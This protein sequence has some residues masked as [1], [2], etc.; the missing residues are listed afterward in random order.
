MRGSFFSSAKKHRDFPIPAKEDTRRS[1]N[2]VLHPAYRGGR[3]FPPDSLK[4]IGM[5][6]RQILPCSLTRKEPIRQPQSHP[7]VHFRNGSLESSRIDRNGGFRRKRFPRDGKIAIFPH[8]IPRFPGREENL[9]S[10]EKI[11]RN[12]REWTGRRKKIQRTASKSMT[13]RRKMG[14]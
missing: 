6:P 11:G 2:A 9:T 13:V 1:G 3:P 7:F 4:S 12:P 5:K 8:R 14:I 10:S